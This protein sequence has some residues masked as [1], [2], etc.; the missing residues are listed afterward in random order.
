[1]K[2]NIR[3]LVPV[4]LLILLLAMGCAKKPPIMTSITPNRGPSGGGTQIRIVG[5]NFKVGATVTVGGKPLLNMSINTEGTE[6]TG[7]V[8]GGTPGTQQV[9]AN[10][11]KAKEPSLPLTF[12]YEE[13]KIVNTS[14]AEG[15]EIPI[16]QKVNQV[17]ASFSQDIDPASVSMSI[18]TVIALSAYDAATKTVTGQSAYDAATKTVTFT[19]DQPFKSGAS[20]QAKVTGAKDMAGNV[21]PDYSINF[22]TQKIQQKVQWYTVQAGDTLPIIAAKPEVYEDESKWR[23][24]YNANQ[25]EFISPD[26]KHGNDIINDYRHLKPGMT[27][28]IPQ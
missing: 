3:I 23:L 22:S 15:T 17:S 27:L 10:N 28:Y 21:I 8:P 20:F 14:L 9:I 18:N 11:L 5:Q 2:R 7:I 26:G 4:F 19:A 1:M 6:V 13:L 24:I 16:G 12:T 25:D